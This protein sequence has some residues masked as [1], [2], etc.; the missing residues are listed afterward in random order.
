MEIIWISVSRFLLG[1]FS[2][3]V[4]YQVKGI[5]KNLYAEKQFVL[6]YNQQTQECEYLYLKKPKES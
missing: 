1:Y 3:L 5:L 4:K 6:L 2:T